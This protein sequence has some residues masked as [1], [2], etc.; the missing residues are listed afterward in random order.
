LNFVASLGKEFAKGLPMEAL[1]LCLQN[2]DW[3]QQLIEGK[4]KL[5]EELKL[6]E[7]SSIV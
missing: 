3:A 6:P 2:R 4:K 5:G 7:Q 1:N